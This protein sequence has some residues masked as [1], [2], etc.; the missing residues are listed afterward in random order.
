MKHYLFSDYELGEDF[1]VGAYDEE[2]ACK[3]ARQFFPDPEFVDEISEFEAENSGLD[4]Y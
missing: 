2:E 4:E 1:I 3:I